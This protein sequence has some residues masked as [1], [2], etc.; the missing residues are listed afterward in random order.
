VVIQGVDVFPS[1][2]EA[3]LLAVEGT[4]PPYRIVLSQEGGLDR[5]EVQIEVTPQIFSDQVS[6]L[7]SLHGKLAG[8]IEE[9]LGVHVPVRLVEP[10]TLQRSGTGKVVDKRDRRGTSP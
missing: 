8:E 1:Q 7:E 6:A 10:H 4:L 3:A 2:I 5:V 9:A